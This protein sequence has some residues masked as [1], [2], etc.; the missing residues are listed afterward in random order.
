VLPLAT[1]TVEPRVT[2]NNST[3][4]LPFPHTPDRMV[5]TAVAVPD[6]TSLPPDKGSPLQIDQAVL[7]AAPVRVDPL[8]PE[9]GAAPVFRA[10]R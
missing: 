4:V 8:D 10:C 7:S 9:G 6:A 5:G 3:Q 1:F 2:A